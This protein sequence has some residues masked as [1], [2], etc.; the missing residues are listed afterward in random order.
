MGIGTDG[1]SDERR[2]IIHKILSN[3]G[4]PSVQVE[5]TKD[6]LDQCVDLAL[7]ELRRLSSSTYQ[8][9]FFFLQV[10]PNK[11]RYTLTNIS[12][13]FN[14]IHRVLGVKRRTSTFLGQ[15]E[16]QAVY[17]QLVLQHLYQMG[18]FD[19]VSYHIISDYVKMMEILF[20]NR[21]M[22][23][24]D[25]KERTL[26][27]FQTFRQPEIVII[28]CACE[29][30]EQDIFAD[31]FLYSWL[32]NWAISLAD[33]RLANIRGKFQTLPG[34]GGGIAL[35]VADLRADAKDLQGRCLQELE[36][37]VVNS[38]IEE[39]GMETQFIFG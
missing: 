12:Q 14:T 35:N 20:A 18:T 30:T 17:G 8:R 22:Y 9:K 19:L 2:D 31:R 13:K 23:L 24:W 28:D 36:D 3:F 21:V 32:L 6:D 11:Q 5:L 25:E 16:G 1:T 4:W 15:A 33:I 7:R 29:R 39:F 26:D 34:A 27:I 37:W 10:M 38:N